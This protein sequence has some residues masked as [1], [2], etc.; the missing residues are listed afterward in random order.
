MDTWSEIL[1]QSELK[2]HNPLDLKVRQLSERME[3]LS[4]LQ[5]VKRVPLQWI[6]LLGFSGSMPNGATVLING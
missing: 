1:G 6:F 4:Y 5:P 3:N 2:I